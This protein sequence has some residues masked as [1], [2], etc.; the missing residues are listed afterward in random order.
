M[1][2]RQYPGLGLRGDWDLGEDNWKD[3]NDANLLT[4]SVLTQGRVLAIQP[5]ETD[6]PAQGDV[7][8]LDATHATQPN[9]IAAYDEGAWVYIPAVEGMAMWN[10][11]DGARYE[12]KAGAWAVATAAGAMADL[13]DVD[14]TGLAD[15][16]V[17]VWNVAQ[18]KFLP[19]AGGGGSGGAA[20]SAF[21]VFEHQVAAGVGGGTPT[22]ATWTTR[23][24]NTE[25]LNEIAGAG[26]ASNQITLPAGK[27]RITARTPFY[28]TNRAETRFRNITDGTTAL[29]GTAAYAD[30]S[31]DGDQT[32]SLIDGVIVL[33]APKTFALQYY[34][35]LASG[36]TN[37]LGVNSTQ[38]ATMFATVAVEK[39]AA[40][41]VGGD[42]EKMN[43]LPVV[44]PG[45]EDG[46]TGWTVSGI[47][48]AATKDGMNPF[49]GAS[50][51]VSDAVADASGYQD[52]SV[53]EFAA[54]IDGGGCRAVALCA[55]AQS[56]TIPEEGALWLEFRDGGGALIDARLTDIH[57]FDSDGG[58]W[59]GATLEAR[60]P[61][62]TR[63]LRLGMRSRRLDGTNNNVAFD[64]F[65]LGLI[66]PTG[67]GQGTGPAAPPATTELS[68]TAHDLLAANAGRFMRFTNAGAKTYTVRP[69]A[70]ESLPA[71]GEWHLRNAGAGNLTIVA[72]SGVTINAPAGGSL[73]VPDRGTVT[74]KR[75]A[76]NVFDLMGY[77]NAP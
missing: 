21:A 24:L 65:S 18:G 2:S 28:R 75:V 12:F 53:S 13:S 74:L 6:P 33:T 37:G 55:L 3:E 26:L 76:I 46:V 29:R 72:G 70:T 30:D 22:A 62:N 25:A 7:V 61:V 5:L 38:E 54:A 73:V 68:G 67:G 56:F 14:L 1:A 16:N 32:L 31:T 64:A 51:F 77:T 36:G 35:E 43:W 39:I 59:E 49:R 44:N 57:S 58:Q 52:V 8:I 9:A 50:M 19:G 45:A 27:Y 60:V 15:G 10:L 20:S 48:S 41:A 11:A 66:T 63:T 4:L 17:L 71:N 42:S 34:A 69:D 40:A 23:V 47:S